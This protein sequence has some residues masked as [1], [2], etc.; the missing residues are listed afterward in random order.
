MKWRRKSYRSNDPPQN[1]EILNQDLT[2]IWSPYADCFCDLQDLKSASAI[3][4]EARRLAEDAKPCKKHKFCCPSCNPA[5][6]GRPEVE[7]EKPET[8][9]SS[10]YLLNRLHPIP[11]N[12]LHSQDI[13]SRE[14]KHKLDKKAWQLHS[15]LIQNLPN[16][17]YDGCICDI[18]G[19]DNAYQI[20]PNPSSCVDYPHRHDCLANP[21]LDTQDPH[22]AHARKH[23]TQLASI[24]HFRKNGRSKSGRKKFTKKA[25]MELEINCG[26]HYVGPN[27]WSYCGCDSDDYIAQLCDC[28]DKNEQ[29]S[30]GTRDDKCQKC[31]PQCSPSY[32]TQAAY[33][34][35]PRKKHYKRR[36]TTTGSPSKR[37]K[38]RHAMDGQENLPMQYDPKTI[39][40]DI[41]RAAGFHPSEPSLNPLLEEATLLKA[42]SKPKLTQSRKRQRKSM[43]NPS[44]Y[45]STEFIVTD[46]DTEC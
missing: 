4:D 20:V 14:D 46:S 18:L 44:R 19:L 22:P 39:A 40:S 21:N 31:C 6:H 25:V 26:L 7:R 8:A 43:P 38:Q 32:H 5:C 13:I 15:S 17:P 24:H 2:P 37:R 23:A 3:G 16:N 28:G 27:R 30:F 34:D 1:L 29:R 12:S 11:Q 35:S 36:H 42:T 33:Q 41:L 10:R 9:S 45:K